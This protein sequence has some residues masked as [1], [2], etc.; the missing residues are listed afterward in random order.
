MK[1]PNKVNPIAHPQTHPGTF[2]KIV[3][4]KNTIY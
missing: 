3:G 4:I 2:L 1:V